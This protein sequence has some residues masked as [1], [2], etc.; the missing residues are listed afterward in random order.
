[1]ESQGL[2]DRGDA[3]SVKVALVQTNPTVGDLPGNA[4]KIRA[5]IGQAKSAGCDL[6]V[7]PELAVCG[8]TPRDFLA[9]ADFLDAC[10]TVLDSLASETRGIAAVIGFPEKRTG[11]GRPAANALA[12]CA[13]GRVQAL[14]RKCLLP[15]YDVFDE[16][17]YFE[18]ASGPTLVEVAGTKV[19]LTVCEDLWN[20]KGFWT[21]QAYPLDPVAEAV[22]QGA[23][24]VV[25]ASASPYW[26]GKGALRERMISAAAKRH[27]V[28]VLYVNQAGGDDELVYDGRSL[29]FDAAGTLSARGAAFAEDFILVDVDGGKVSG[30]LAPSPESETE[31]VYRALVLGIRDYVSKCGFRSVV[32]GL[33]GGVDSALTACLAVDALGAKNVL[34]VSMP[35]RF[36]SGHSQTD[37]ATLARN[38]GMKMMLVPL[39]GV[40]AAALSALAP[41]FTALQPDSTE[42]NLQARLRCQVLMAFSNKFGHLLL[43]TGNKSELAMGYCTL[44]GDMAGGFNALCDVPKTLVYTLSRWVN[45]GGERIPRGSIEKPP[46]AEL[47]PNQ[48][49]QDSLPPYPLLDRV[50]EQYVDEEKAPASI[51]GEGVTPELVARIVAAVDRSEFKRRQAAPGIKISARAFGTGRRLPIAHGWTL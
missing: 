10:R 36:S 34:G 6:V 29:A 35:S 7:F 25:N 31:A 45:R 23:L 2:W 51:T 11:P 21:H 18:P 26:Q 38:L 48:T 27:G 41:A 16:P 20:D 17:R 42:E 3:L 30:S 46:S 4:T 44:Y 13:D 9:R 49:D 40:H 15:A 43:T 22:K 47:R 39:E 5:G 8:Y 37:A 50:L 14:G 28:P 33:S 24:L 12:F 32:L 19:A 1:M